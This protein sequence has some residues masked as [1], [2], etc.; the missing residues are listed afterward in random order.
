MLPTKLQF[1]KYQSLGNDFILLDWLNMNKF[2]VEKCLTAKQWK[3]LVCRL[4]DRHFGIGADG[5]LIIFKN[6]KDQFV[7]KIFNADGS[8]GEKC[9]NGLRCAANYIS[10]KVE[11]TPQFN[12]LMGDR[13]HLCDIQVNNP[14]MKIAIDVGTSNGKPQ[15]HRITCAGKDI[16]GY[17]VNFG[18][19]HFVVLQQTTLDWLRDN[20]R[21]IEQH[22]DFPFR[23]NTEFVWLNEELTKRAN[24]KIYDFLVYERGCGI[25]YAC[26]SGAAAALSVLHNLDIVTKEERVLFSML[27][28]M[29]ESNFDDDDHI[30]QRASVNMVFEGIVEWKE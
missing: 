7:T 16:E 22:N 4:C 14:E 26:G 2:E 9:L 11:K 17:I 19:P 18:N 13:L 3:E 1:S 5:V 6:S 21:Y 25:T 24:F 23:I 10:E 30:L 8:D 28:G 20:G 27:G 29:L 15:K 12:I